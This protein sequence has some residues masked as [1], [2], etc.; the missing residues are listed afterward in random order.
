MKDR[1]TRWSAAIASSVLAVTAIAAPAAI[2]EEYSA[3][4]TPIRLSSATPGDHDVNLP[5]S[6]EQHPAISKNNLSLYF[7]SDRT[8]YGEFDI[9]VAKRASRSDAWDDAVNLGAVINTVGR[10]FAPN[11]TP[12]GHW[13]YFHSSRPG[14]CNTVDNVPLINDL[15]RSHRKHKSDDLGWEP[16]ENLGCA[17]NTVYNE[18]GPTYFADEANE[19]VTLY[20]TSEGRPDSLGGFDI[21]ASTLQEDGTFGP[22]VHVPELSS[23]YRDTRTAIRKDGLELFISTERPGGVDL[24]DIWVATRQSTSDPWSAPVPL[25]PTINSTCIDSGPALSWDGTELYFYSQRPVVPD[26]PC[27]KSDLFVARRQKIDD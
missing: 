22:G 5:G 6:N 18:G 27:G 16:P 26:G 21:Y 25:G 8:G 17:I 11:F 15:W 4:S 20:F 13:L 14:G 10:D 12:D 9:Y 2:A 3:W 7:V 23:P 19:T 1:V 24:R